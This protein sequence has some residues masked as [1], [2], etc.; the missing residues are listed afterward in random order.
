MHQRD[1]EPQ[2]LAVVDQ[3]HA[4]VSADVDRLVVAA[5][6]SL[7]EHGETYGAL[8]IAGYLAE[9][10]ELDRD[11]LL[12]LLSLALAKLAVTS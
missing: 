11:A 9:R 4:S 5:R 12:G 8:M 3:V 10:D 1:L 7:A 6:M 2:T